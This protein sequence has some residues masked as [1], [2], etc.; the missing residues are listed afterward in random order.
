MWFNCHS[1]ASI[2]ATG[3]KPP[4]KPKARPGLRFELMLVQVNRT[5]PALADLSNDGLAEK[6]NVALVDTGCLLKTESCDPIGDGNKGTEYH[7]PRICAVG[8][9]HSGDIWLET[10]SAAEHDLLAE[11]ARRWVPRLSN[12]LSA[13]QKTYPVLIHGILFSFD[14]SRNSDDVHHLITQNNHLILHP[15]A[16]QHV[17]FSLFATMLPPHAK[18]MAPW[19]YTLWRPRLQTI[20]SLTMLHTGAG[21]Y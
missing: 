1:P 14:P 7:M 10:Y 9:H 4:V 16:L 15:A 17:N 13:V 12:Q 20:V 19:L 5:C 8:R 11:T 3:I 6:V 18:L 2:L 21:C